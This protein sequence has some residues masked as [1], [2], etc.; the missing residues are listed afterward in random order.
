MA[1]AKI[2]RKSVTLTPKRSAVKRKQDPLKAAKTHNNKR[3]K[4]KP[5]QNIQKQR[6]MQSDANFL[7]AT[8]RT[9]DRLA[10]QY[11]KTNWK[12][13]SPHSSIISKDTIVIDDTD[14]EN[15]ESVSNLQ[16]NAMQNTGYFYEDRSPG[17][18]ELEIPLYDIERQP[19]E[20]VVEIHETTI[21]ELD[22]TIENANENGQE[23]SKEPQEPD[24][25]EDV[26]KSE[27][28][29]AISNPSRKIPP[30]VLSV[31]DLSDDSE[32]VSYTQFIAPVQTIP[33]GYNIAK[34]QQKVDKQLTKKSPNK[35]ITGT[36]LTVEPQVPTT[37]AS[38]QNRNSKEMQKKRM[39][40]IDGNN[41]SYG[42]LNGKM[43]SVKGLEICIK[44]FK[45]LGHEVV[46][47]VP[48]YKLK[49]TQ[50]TDQELLQK[51][52]RQGD[53]ILAPSK[54]L[55]GQYSSPYDDRLIL[56]VAEKFD[57]VIVSNDNFRDLLDSSPVWR[58][59]IET[60]V[61]GYTWVKDCFFLPD[62]PYG[63]QGPSLSAMLNGYS[64]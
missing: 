14:E 35:K 48:Q 40:V 8:P 44:Y 47:V 17:L 64:P 20:P 37:S 33:L 30:R 22:S 54:N 7:P 46:A 5:L 49:K 42:H 61:I 36:N 60:R 23:N 12:R 21:I 34:S 31:I 6:K 24:S 32:D 3:N 13:I 38:T 27:K 59:I 58:R 16:P 9:S 53:V 19:V 63:R 45:K 62:D 55:P 18:R 29:Y 11:Q 25:T 28:V 50:S 2:P 57:G 56:S 51:L 15:E 41:V 43:F 39:V 52:H 26:S 10:K 1:R 4:L